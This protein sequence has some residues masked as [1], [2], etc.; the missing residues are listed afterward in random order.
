MNKLRSGIRFPNPYTIWINDKDVW[1]FHALVESFSIGGSPVKNE[2]FHGR[3]RSSWTPLSHTIDLKQITFSLFFSG[4]TRRAITLDKSSVDALLIGKVELHM[5]D[6]FYYTASLKSLGEL[7][8]LGVEGNRVIGLCAY[9]LEGI[10]HDPLETVIG[11]TIY[12][13]G[14]LPVMD[15]ILKCTTTSA[16]ATLQMGPV[17]FSDVPAGA[18]VVANGMTG[19]LTVNGANVKASF[20]RL[21]C[22]VPG[23]QTITC[24]E[25]LTVQYYPSYI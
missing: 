9:K 20:T 21:P 15:A 8:I 3:N 23:L 2:I 16:R 1:E 18:T 22:L 24:P 25:N 11:N 7:K 14:T 4:P 6:G 10:Q 13:R 17:T 12:A 19:E 5:P